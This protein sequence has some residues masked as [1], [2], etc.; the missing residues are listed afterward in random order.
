MSDSTFGEVISS[1]SRAQALADGALVDVSNVA[2]EMGFLYRV[3]LTAAVWAD[4]VAWNDEDSERQV[5]QN[6][7]ARLWD[8]LW[9]AK[10]ADKAGQGHRVAFELRRVPRGGRG[11]APRR[12]TLRLAIGPGDQGE[13]V[14]TIL[15]P[16]E[17]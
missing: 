5:M 2:R 1:Y 10:L 12:V 6:E 15:L 11:Q 13:P 3:T 17:D 16:D 14:L 7:N 4:C 8:V 9:M